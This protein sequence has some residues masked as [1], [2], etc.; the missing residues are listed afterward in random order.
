[1]LSYFDEFDMPKRLIFH[2]IGL[3]TKNI[4]LT[5]NC[6]QTLGFCATEVII[7]PVQ[8][9]KVC[10]LRKDG[11]P[12]LELLKPLDAESPVNNILDKVGTSLYHICYETS[13][14]EG[15]ISFLRKNKFLNI[16]KPV[17]AVALINRKIAFLYSKDAGLIELI[18]RTK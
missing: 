16:A 8:K 17:Q 14:M 13:D 7:D 10:F 5:R 1:L 6:Y 4:S 12:P 18:E 2:H 11:H 9:V 15:A 3:A